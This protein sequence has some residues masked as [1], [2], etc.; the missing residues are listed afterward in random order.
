M[1]PQGASQATDAGNALKQ[2]PLHAVY[3][4]GRTR[5]R[6]TAEAIA[7]PHALSPMADAALCERHFGEWEN[8]LPG[9]L[10]AQHPDALFRLWNDP[11]FSPPGGE[12]ARE[13]ADRAV[14]AVERLTARHA[15]QTVAV[16]AHAGSVRA[17]LAHHLGVELAHSLRMEIWPAHGCLLARYPDGGVTL[18]GINLPAT[19]WAG[20]WQQL[21]GNAIPARTNPPETLSANSGMIPQSVDIHADQ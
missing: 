5:S 7:A 18:G 1:S 8:T 11:D 20:A 2:V 13:L 9:Q 15:G 19:S 6:Q 21:S 17:A 4:S 14:S 12:S 16:V 3:T 10:D